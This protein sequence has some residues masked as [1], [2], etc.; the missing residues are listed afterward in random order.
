MTNPS[1]FLLLLTPTKVELYF[2]EVVGCQW[3]VVAI[4]I[5]L[6]FYWYGRWPGFILCLS[7]VGHSC[8]KCSAFILPVPHVRMSVGP[9]LNFTNII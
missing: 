9:I 3:E 4:T 1:C 7:N 8:S 6:V 5:Q 2:S